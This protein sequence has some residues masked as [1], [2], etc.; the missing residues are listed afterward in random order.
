MCRITS[1][2][3][4][5]RL[6]G[7]MSGDA[8][9]FNKIETRTVIIFFFTARQGAEGNSR[10][11]KRKGQNYVSIILINA[12]KISSAGL[13]SMYR[14]SKSYFWHPVGF[15]CFKNCTINDSSLTVLY[16]DRFLSTPSNYAGS[17]RPLR[18][19]DNTCTHSQQL[20]STFSRSDRSIYFE[21]D[22][23]F[24][25]LEGRGMTADNFS[26]FLAVLQHKIYQTDS[27]L[28]LILLTWTIWRAPTNASKWRMGF[29]PYPANVD[30]MASSY[31]C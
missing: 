5:Q 24:S 9:D 6:K 25:E 17:V 3:L 18:P 14:F 29:N 19:S 8:R 1:L 10:H 13:Q 22:C 20:I 4:L 12:S 27:L 11:S 23:L 30:N 28:T 31:Q 16:S 2:F 15:S 21:T 26:S 7:S